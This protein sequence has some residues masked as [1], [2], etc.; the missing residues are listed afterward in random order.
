MLSLGGVAYE[1]VGLTGPG[2]AS[3]PAAD[4][5]LPLQADRFSRDLANTL[6]VVGRLSKGVTM[7]AADLV[8]L[9][10]SYPFYTQLREDPFPLPNIASSVSRCRPSGRTWAGR[11]GTTA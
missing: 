7:D 6:H 11:S 2:F 10:A 5:W 8:P 1:I 3:A 4:L 9:Y